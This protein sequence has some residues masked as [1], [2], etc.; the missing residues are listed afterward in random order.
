MLT[1]SGT[2]VLAVNDTGVDSR[3]ID[4]AFY[5]SNDILF[6]NPN[7]KSC[8]TREGLI[9]GRDNAEKVFNFL[10]STE[11]T[12]LQG[13]MNAIQ[14]AGVL[15]N[16][17]RESGMD[18]AAIESTGEG[19]GLAQWSYTR[20][21]ALFEFAESQGMEWSD[22]ELQLQFLKSE[23]DGSEG[24][25]LRHHGFNNVT[26]PVEAAE[27]FETAYERAGF[28]A[29]EQRNQYAEQFYE[30]FG[31]SSNNTWVP[32]GDQCSGTSGQPTGDFASDEFIT[33]SQCATGPNSGPWGNHEDPWGRTSCNVGCGPVSISMVIKNMTG[34]SITPADVLQYYSD[35]GFWNPGGGS[36]PAHMQAAAE[37][38]GL[39]YETAS[40][41]TRSIDSYREHFEAGGLIVVNGQGA[42]PFYAHVR[43]YVVARGITADG[44]RIIVSDPGRGK[45]AEWPIQQFMASTNSNLSTVFY[46][47][48]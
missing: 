43:H 13:S 3:S 1:L 5:S 16:F 25:N 10:T 2:Q 12:G 39:R 7:D 18:P 15:G 14:A 46:P 4:E 33:W 28:K 38:W 27:I 20:K 30:T 41:D 9:S 40:L 35:N 47:A 19:H 22:L 8:A 26:T 44:Q 24:T 23:L 32:A 11:F 34:A 17:Q 31:S 42:E 45:S 6:Y 21:T 48:N 29:Q 37:H 36:N